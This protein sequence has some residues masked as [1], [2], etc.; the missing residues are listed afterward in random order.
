MVDT[1]LSRLALASHQVSGKAGELQVD[2]RCR[3]SVLME[4]PGA[5]NGRHCKRLGRVERAVGEMLLDDGSCGHAALAVSVS[6]VMEHGDRA[7]RS[8][9]QRTGPGILAS[10]QSPD[11]V[12]IERQRGITANVELDQ[13]SLA[14]HGV[15]SPPLCVWSASSIV[16]SDLLVEPNELVLEAIR[17][18]L[19][20]LSRALFRR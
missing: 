1:I 20:G 12:L 19:V 10:L 2:R 4:V 6:P 8:H 15:R 5:E 16:I 3:V 11:D 14:V 7:L 18:C 13:V 17:H 9:E